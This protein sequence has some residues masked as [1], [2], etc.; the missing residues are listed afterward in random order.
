MQ[1]QSLLIYIPTGPMPLKILTVESSKY[2]PDI[3]R[4]MPNAE[5]YATAIEIDDAAPYERLKVN[6]VP[7]D[8]RRAKL[9]F[10]DKQFDI[11][12]AEECL[13]WAFE[14]YET[15]MDIS[16]KLKDTGFAVAAFYNAR[17]HKILRE[18]ALGRFNVDGRR[19]WTKGDVVKIFN[20]A[21]FK[22]IDFAYAE[23]DQA[24]V[25]AFEQL[26]F[27]NYNDDLQTKT[28]LIKAARS[29]A[30]VSALK[31]L[32]SPKTRGELAKLLH[33]IEYDVKREDSLS[34]LAAL[35]DREMIFG[36]YLRDFIRETCAHG[37]RV[38]GSL[39]REGVL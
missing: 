24:D 12:V 19:F 39:E 33:R 5:L 27:D 8:Y 13:T 20:D 37:E 7:F 30:A 4:R 2:L 1:T 38:I 34:A 22:E 36:E 35:I 25:S 17:C 16:R 29:K 23:R 14:P 32:Y 6:A 21:V 11:I 10:A 28:W 26:G 18:L 3:R 15:V 31:T 9:P